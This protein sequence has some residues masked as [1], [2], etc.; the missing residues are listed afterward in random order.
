MAIR[1]KVKINQEDIEAIVDSGASTNI[2][3][4]GLLEVL[5]ID[6]QEPSN[7][8]FIIA[9]GKKV[10]A[11]GKTTIQIVLQGREMEIEAQVMDARKK[12]LILGNEFLIEKDGN[13]DYKTKTLTIK[14]K[15]QKLK[16]PL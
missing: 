9:N 1:C 2:I 13:I 10:A 16:V 12:E 5:Q 11:L 8:S 7:I 6:I 15:E 3:T 4:Q 14:D